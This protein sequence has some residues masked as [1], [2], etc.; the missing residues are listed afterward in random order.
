MKLGKMSFIGE[1][2]FCR[3]IP[4]KV[5]KIYEDSLGSIPSVSS[6]VKIQIII[7]GEGV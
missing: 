4:G 2:D 5:E 7:E 1:S 6:S 3:L